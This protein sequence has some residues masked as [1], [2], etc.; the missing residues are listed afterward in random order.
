[1]ALMLAQGAGCD[2]LVLSNPWTF[3]GTGEDEQESPPEVVRDHYRKRLTDP[4]A[5]KRLLT[6]QVSLGKLF[7]SLIGAAR[8][9]APPTSLAQDIAK[10]IADFPG[11]VTFLIAERDRTGKAFLA[12]WDK[13]DPRVKT[14]VD[15]THAYVEPDARE[16]LEARLVEAL[17]G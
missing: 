12:T 5:I 4:A 13:G 2:A 15:A 8:P 16:W 11:E 17:N 1:S 7:G 10:G 14:C 3:E 9:S 6:G